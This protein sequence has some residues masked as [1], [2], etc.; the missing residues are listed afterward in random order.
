M[1]TIR[2]ATVA[3]AISLA[4]RLRKAD[5]DEMKA[6][7]S[8]PPEVALTEGVKTGTE[9]FAAER[10]GLVVALFGIHHFPGLNEQE[11]TVWMLGSDDAL[12]DKPAFLRVARDFLKRAH[13]RFPLLWNVIDC[14]NTVHIN[15]LKRMGFIAIRKH[16][17]LGIEQRPFF[18]FIRID[19]SCVTSPQPH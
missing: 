19:P 7:T 3:D 14:R 16:E 2:P 1:T 10:D 6:I 15:W 12:R 18:E 5:L 4:P 8:V 13:Q 9:T 17:H 11:A